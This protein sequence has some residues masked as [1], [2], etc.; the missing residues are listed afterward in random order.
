MDIKHSVKYYQE[1]YFIF[2]NFFF[3]HL[4]NKPYFIRCGYNL[5]DDNTRYNYYK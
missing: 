5:A 1:K 3:D 4:I 2:K